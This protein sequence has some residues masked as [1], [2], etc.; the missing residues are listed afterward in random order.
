II[1]HAIQSIVDQ[2]LYDQRVEQEQQYQDELRQLP[3]NWQDITRFL[4]VLDD[5]HE[6]A[7]DWLEE[8]E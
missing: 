3:P 8:M 2:D 7:R 6:L 4:R 1:E 5:N